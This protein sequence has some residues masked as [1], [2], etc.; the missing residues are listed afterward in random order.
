LELARFR[1]LLEKK[2]S[3]DHDAGYTYID[4]VSSESIPFTPFMTKEWAR[5]MVI[6]SLLAVLLN[7]DVLYV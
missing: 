7:I 1:G 6:D 3:N 2:Y 5:A 4:P